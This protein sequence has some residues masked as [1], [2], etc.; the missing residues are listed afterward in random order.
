MILKALAS[1]AWGPGMMLCVRIPL[2]SMLSWN[3]ECAWDKELTA[4]CLVETHTK[5]SVG[6]ADPGCDGKKLIKCWLLLGNTLLVIVHVAVPVECLCYGIIWAGH[7]ALRPR[8]HVGLP[9][10]IQEAVVH[11]EI[12]FLY[13]NCLT[14]KHTTVSYT[15]RFLSQLGL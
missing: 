11:D 1:G 8:G 15:F 4:E 14:L 2:V 9:V 7:S 12:T 10:R 3:I 13:W 5:K 6:N